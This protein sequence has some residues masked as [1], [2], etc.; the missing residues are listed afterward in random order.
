[1]PS[2]GVTEGLAVGVGFGGI[3]SSPV[4]TVAS[5]WALAIGIGECTDVAPCAVLALELVGIHVALHPVL[6]F[7]FRVTAGLQNFPEGKP[8]VSSAPMCVS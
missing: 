1:M 8:C 6:L 7:V 5:A 4:A 3:G 2:V